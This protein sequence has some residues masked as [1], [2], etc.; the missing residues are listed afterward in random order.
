MVNLIL[1]TFTG[2]VIVLTYMCMRR[3]LEYTASCFLSVTKMNTAARAP[4]QTLSL[5]TMLQIGCIGAG[6]EEVDYY[7]LIKENNGYGTYYYDHA[8]GYTAAKDMQNGA[9]P[10]MLTLAP[11]YMDIYKNVQILMFNDEDDEDGVSNSKAHQKGVIA[12]DFNSGNG[13][14]LQHSTPKFPPR[15]GKPLV[16]DS[17]TYGQHFL[18]IDID[19]KGL[20]NIS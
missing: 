11:L 9:N 5:L 6:R 18:C 8:V 13:F 15:P 7:I 20:L 14:Y 2:L 19:L 1:Y 4:H 17:K 12:F 3:Q 10:V 16:Y